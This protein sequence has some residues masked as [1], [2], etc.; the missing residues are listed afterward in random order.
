MHL[1][2]HLNVIFDN[3]ECEKVELRAEGSVNLCID[4]SEYVMV[5]LVVCDDICVVCQCFVV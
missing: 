1:E 2:L 4:G 5:A 3:F